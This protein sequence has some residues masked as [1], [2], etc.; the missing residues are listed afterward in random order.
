MNE[1][2]A[3]PR[4]TIGSRLAHAAVGLALLSVHLITAKTADTQVAVVLA[5]IGSILGVTGVAM[6][7]R[8]KRR[9]LIG[10]TVFFAALLG[11]LAFTSL[12]TLLLLVAGSPWAEAAA[13]WLGYAAGVGLF[14]GV[15][16]AAM[17][18]AFLGGA[19]WK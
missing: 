18:Y 16:M 15:G 8:R 17:R 4:P 1:V 11:P 2:K 3:L 13:G 9:P 19:F 14:Y 12:L 7:A 10:K 5:L 6:W